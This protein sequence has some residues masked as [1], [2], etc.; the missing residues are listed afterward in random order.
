MSH[1]LLLALTSSLLFSIRRSKSRLLGLAFKDQ[2][3]LLIPLAD[4]SFPL[5]SLRAL[6][7]VKL[8]PHSFSLLYAIPPAPLIP[9][10]HFLENHPDLH[11]CLQICS[12]QP[13]FKI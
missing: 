4:S 12:R 8:N 11:L 3:F 7:S 9:F 2:V 5:L 10:L 1:Y 6:C 13:S